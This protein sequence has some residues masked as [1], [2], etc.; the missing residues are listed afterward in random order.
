VPI[1]RDVGTQA[2]AGLVNGQIAQL[3]PN[4]AV[5]FTDARQAVGHLEAVV[6]REPAAAADP[7]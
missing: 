1:G 5:T 4:R 7:G 2:L 6:A 3:E